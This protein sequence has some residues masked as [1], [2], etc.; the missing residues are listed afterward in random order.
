MKKNSFIEGT[1]VASIAI[2][3]T[4]ILG[5]IYVIPFYKIVGENGGVLYS[6]AY[7]IYNLFLNISTAGIPPAIAMIISEFSTLGMYDAR[8]RAFKVSKKLVIILSVL[9]FLVLFIFAE[10]IGVFYLRGIEGGN[11]VADVALVIRSISFCLLIS[12]FLSTLRGFLQ[13]NKFIAPSSISQVIEQ[14]IRIAIIIGGSYISI[15]ILKTSVTVGVAVALTGA[16]FG[17]VFAYIYL[18]FKVNRNKKLFE[19]SK[20]KDTITN[21]EILKKL[22]SYAIPL[23]MISVIAN[24]YD[25]ID[26]RLILR[27]LTMINYSGADAELISSIICTWGPKICMIMVAISLGLTTSLIPHLV[28]SYTKGDMGEVNRRFNQALGYLFVITIPMAIGIFLLADPIYTLF[29]GQSYYGPII[30]KALAVLNVVTGFL[31]IINT[32]LQGLKKFNVIYLT[33]GIGLVVSTAL[34]LPLILLFNKIG[35]YPFYG[36]II[37]TVIGTSISITS[38]FM[39]FR[40]NFKFNYKQTFITLKKLIIPALAMILVIIGLKYFISF[41]D[42]SYVTIILY[43]VIFI[44]VS[45]IVYF[46]IGYKNGLLDNVFGK[47]YIDKILIKLHLKKKEKN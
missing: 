39:Y 32:T 22:V 21:K 11:S 36:T 5:A 29:Y 30:L 1:I 42:I 41:K 26:L 6:Y 7:N 46:V 4:K 43:L 16:F 35:I 20:E 12:A 33:T 37:A 17:A 10:S 38:V 25:L 27:G 3:I 40:K 2:I 34:D 28:D 47:D 24:L 13:G 14:V 9:A 31:A 23:I 19:K 8:D 15:N 44:I 18:R 45:A